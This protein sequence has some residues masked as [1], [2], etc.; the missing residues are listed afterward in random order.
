LAGSFLSAWILFP[1]VLLACS[2]GGGLLVRRLSGGALSAGLV[3][4]VGFALIVVVCAFATSF[5]RLA[6]AA[7]AIVLVSALLGFALQAGSGGLRL[8]PRPRAVFSS[9]AG[10]WL[11]PALA[12]LVAFAAFGGP[13][14]LTGT[15]T[16][17]GYTR[18]VDIAFQMDF[19]KHLA[20]AGRTTPALDSS[21]HSIAHSLTAIGYP[22]G[23]QATLGA[24]ANLIRT[25]VPWCYQAYLAF[26][27]AVGAL[28]IFSLLGRITA[29]GPLRA[30][31]AAVAIQ[32]NILYGYTLEGGIKEI[33][34]ATLLMAVFALLA[35]R[36]PGDGSRRSV[37]PTAVALSAA[38]A[39]FSA[40]IAPWLGLV[41]VGLLAVTLAGRGTR[42]RYVAECWTLL[43]GFS[44]LLSFPSLLSA[45][46]LAAAEGATI[47]GVLEIGL[48]NLAA[49]VPDWSSAGVW[50]TGDYRYPLVHTTATHAFDLVVIL[51]AI[52]GV[53]LALRRRLWP[54]AF[55]GLAAP[56]ALYFWIEHTG[57]WV[58]LKAFTITAAIALVLAFAGAAA[59]YELR[60]R[61]LKWVG[62]LAAA[63]IAG[64]VLYGNAIIYHDTSLAPAARY[65]DLAAIGKRYAG[66][67]PT[68]F[69]AF[70]EPSEYFL[71]EER[72]ADLVEPGIESVRLA[73]GVGSPPGVTSFTWDLN[74]LAPSFVQSFPLI[75]MP[76]SP[77]ASRAPSNFD[78]VQRTRYF[79]VWRRDRPSATMVAHFPLAGLPHERQERGFCGPFLG[80][81]RQAGPGA[82]VAYAQASPAVVT[83]VPQ[84]TH[85]D[86]WKVVGP[87]TA[88]AYGAGAA[89]MRV[90]LPRS[91]RYGIW[92]QGSVGRPL[93]FYLD[94]RRLTTIGYEERYPNQFLLLSET[95]LAAGTHT[96][97]VVR[98]NGSLQ[99]GSGGTSIDTEGDTLGAIVFG[100][101]DARTDRVYVAPASRAAQV[102]AAPVGYE[103]LEILKPG[104]APANA[105]R[106]PT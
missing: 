54:I 65:Q 106:A 48:G 46:K 40:G 83:G 41:F 69:P 103:W 94:G 70:D 47:S 75:V 42:R 20:D 17:T 21:Y 49:P 90:V 88:I 19:A 79:D 101:E 52:L 2:A 24:M 98:G 67:G 50:L 39:A 84:G 58:Q 14:F 9:D 43:A 51:L 68:L 5:G 77:V 78:L 91:G 53:V 89:Q 26:A 85:P 96:L 92:M 71:R 95:T 1:V 97:R 35:E 93:D 44:V 34:A 25:D 80:R 64:V 74:Q 31:G 55:L 62:W 57:P 22:G 45:V 18:I 87:N 66:R 6:P 73:P 30:T 99:P 59:L 10:A 8:P 72:G 33:T 29:S 23:G 3:V 7:G 105:L 32:P 102:C 56:I 100:T 28:A 82:E 4:P 12:A 63:V 104:G 60:Y 36:L 16:W 11:W 81:V 13:V 61:A 15:T 38:F 27:A 86:Y 76:R 37:L